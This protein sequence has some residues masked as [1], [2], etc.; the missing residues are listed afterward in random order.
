MDKYRIVEDI[1]DQEGL[2]PNFFGR[3]LAKKSIKMDVKASE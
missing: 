2:P 3:Y 1:L